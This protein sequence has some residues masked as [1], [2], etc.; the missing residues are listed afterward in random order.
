M[1]T[2]AALSGVMM[3]FQGTCGSYSPSTVGAILFIAPGPTLMSFMLKNYAI[4]YVGP[5]KATLLLTTESIFCAALSM[6]LFHAQI[7]WKMLIGIVFII[8][9]ILLEEIGSTRVTVKVPV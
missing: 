7:T 1:L 9:G 3:L 4:K 6:A 8:S 2:I 5:I